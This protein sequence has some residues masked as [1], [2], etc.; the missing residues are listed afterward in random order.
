MGTRFMA[1]A[2]APIHDNVKRRIFESDERS[3][4]LLYRKF[5][6]TARVARNA[7]S[8]QI[9]AIEDEPAPIFAAIADPASGARARQPRYADGHV[10]GGPWTLR[11]GHGWSDIQSV[12]ACI[13][14]GSRVAP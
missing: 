7:V 11:D 9:R 14:Q 2:E 8:R 3:T 10:D 12:S 6:N 13:S 1:T 5:R 4:D